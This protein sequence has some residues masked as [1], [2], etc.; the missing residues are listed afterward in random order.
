MGTTGSLKRSGNHWSLTEDTLHSR[1]QMTGGVAFEANK[2]VKKLWFKPFRKSAIRW[3]DTLDVG[4]G[5]PPFV[6]YPKIDSKSQVIEK[7]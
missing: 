3:A 7:S 2:K 1:W 5:I 6:H 4:L